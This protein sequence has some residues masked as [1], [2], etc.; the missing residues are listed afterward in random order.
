MLSTSVDKLVDSF[1]NPTIPPINDELTS[2][3]IHAIHKLLNSNAVYVNT[4]LGC[5]TLGY[6]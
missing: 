2:V 5:G 4:K 6:L 1:K 3:T